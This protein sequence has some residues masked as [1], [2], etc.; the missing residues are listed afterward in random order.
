MKLDGLGDLLFRGTLWAVGG[1]AGSR[2]TAE[3]SEMVPGCELFDRGANCGGVDRVEFVGQPDFEARRRPR[4]RVLV[5]VCD[6]PPNEADTAVDGVVVEIAAQLL[7]SWQSHRNGGAR[8]LSACC[9]QL[10]SRRFGHICPKRQARALRLPN[11]S[12]DENGVLYW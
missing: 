9:K 8:I 1:L 11:D 3:P 10:A 6:E 2:F 5:G 4:P 7:V 12:S